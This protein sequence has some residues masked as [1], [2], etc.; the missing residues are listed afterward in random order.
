MDSAIHRINLYALDRAI[1]FPSTYSLDS[2]LSLG[3]HYP[4]FEQLGPGGKTMSF[5]TVNAKGS[6]LE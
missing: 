2:D 3:L 6:T 1:G 4:A 5:Y